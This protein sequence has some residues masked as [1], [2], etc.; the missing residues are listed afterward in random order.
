[1]AGSYGGAFSCKRG[2]PVSNRPASAS[3]P[4]CGRQACALPCPRTFQ[5]SLTVP[6]HS[7]GW[8]RASAGPIAPIGPAHPYGG[9]TLLGLALP[10]D[11]REG[12]VLVRAVQGICACGMQ[13]SL[14]AGPLGRGTGGMRESNFNSDHNHHAH[15]VLHTV[16][17]LEEIPTPLTPRRA[18]PPEL[19]G[20]GHL[21][22]R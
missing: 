2:I 3:F 5:L 16:Q 7:L 4:P 12:C 6:A 14:F 11:P 13:S 20:Q 8:L 1:M 19:R 9:P 18:E 15:H 22:P 17:T 10:K 21:T